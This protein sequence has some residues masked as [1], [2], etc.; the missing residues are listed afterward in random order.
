VLADGLVKG[1][2][3]LSLLLLLPALG[4]SSLVTASAVFL[5]EG[6]AKLLSMFPARRLDGHPPRNP[7]V[8]VAAGLSV[9]LQGACLALPALRRAMGL[10]PVGLAA[11]AV[12]G[13]A[14]L[15]TYLLGELLLALLRR[16]KPDPELAGLPT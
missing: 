8:L 14:L 13:L 15:S 12:V 6:V 10:E 5:Y 1:G 4:M 16:R 9:A 2:F 3:G 7:W 11:L